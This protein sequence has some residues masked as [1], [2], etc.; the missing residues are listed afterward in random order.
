MC[1]KLVTKIKNCIIG[2]VKYII[3]TLLFVIFLF[4]FLYAQ[5]NYKF[6]YINTENGLPTNAIKGLQFDEKNRFL[7]VATESGILRYNGHGFQNFSD[8][9]ISAALNG[10]I[11][12]FGKTISGELF[13]KLM[14]E[15]VFSINENNAIIE[16]PVYLM[17]DENAYL[18]YKYNL[19]KSKKAH[20]V[21]PIQLRDIKVGEN[22]YVKYEYALY[23]YKN[24]QFITIK[25]TI[26]F[27]NEFVIN[28]NLFI[29]KKNG[30]LFKAIIEKNNLTLSQPLNIHNISKTDPNNVF[31]K[32]KIFQSNPNDPVYL[33]T[34]EKL[35][36]LTYINNT[37]DLKLITDQLPN[38]EFIKYVQIDHLT[39][40]IFIG[41]DNRGIIVGRP[42]YFKRVLPNNA[43]D[44][45]SSSAYAQ[46]QLSNGNIQINSGQIFGES[47]I[48]N[49]NVFY[50]PSETST[51]ISNDSILF[52]SNSDGLVEYNLRKNKIDYISKEINVN[53]NSI[54]Q[55]GN[56]IYCF[57]E[58]GVALKKDKWV[59]ILNHKKMPFNFIVYNLMQI[60]N[61]EI[62][63]AT[64]HG[65]Y[66][67]NLVKNAFQLFYNDKDNSNFRAIYN[68]NGYYLIGTYGGGVY[69]FYKDAIK[70]LPLDQN[71]YLNY[72]HCFIEDSKGNV[73][74]S[75]NKGLFMS[76]KKSLIDFW[77]NGPGNIKFKYFGKNEGIDQ[78][79]MNGGCN[80]CAIKLRNGNLSFPGIDGLI[81]FNPDNLPEVNI[82]PRVYI[83]KYL[84]II[85]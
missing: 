13:G 9:N 64:T 20:K 19:G 33:V 46:F 6:E 25:D 16:N 34:G 71:K 32:V 1:I 22:I 2:Q 12:I 47:K 62:L 65:L 36:L 26:E 51:Y 14:D 56:D 76:P 41:T 17:D 69:M 48:K 57:N 8:N 10:R 18:N 70:K 38:K 78:L 60:N 52:M 30:I 45:I 11:V 81:Q 44:G 73:W 39:N 37:I 27:D 23:Q 49:E 31:G 75:T 58:L 63:V 84:L 85:N 3:F 72:T 59:Y 82:Q 35:F 43:I 66:K 15:R 68:L 42:Q 79:E 29:V 74:A 21:Y 54:I 4:N 50:R 67:Y 5:S 83:D 28:N 55:V 77:N 80:P 40:T 53:R 61:N 24:N 7:W